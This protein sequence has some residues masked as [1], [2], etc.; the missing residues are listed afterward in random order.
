MEV[1][2]ATPRPDAS[3][4]FRRKRDLIL[5]AASR[6]INLRGLKGLT[7]VGVAEAVGLNT[8]SITYYFKRKELLAAA[9]LERG[10]DRWTELLR[11]AARADS[12]RGRVRALIHEYLETIIRIRAGEEPPLTLLSD[13]RA[14]EDDNRTRLIQRYQ[15][16]LWKTAAFFGPMPDTAAKARNL[17]GLFRFSASALSAGLIGALTFTRLAP[18]DLVTRR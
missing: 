2:P 6:Q 9:T 5:D 3:E 10:V 14:L 17:A 8:T 15:R 11:N 16:L 18:Q 13:M 12:H 7:F 1:A 4:K